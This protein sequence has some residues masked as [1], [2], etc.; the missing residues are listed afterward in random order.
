MHGK[1]FL[2]LSS[3]FLLSGNILA[4]DF[5]TER[6]DKARTAYTIEKGRLAIEPELVNYATQDEDNAYVL[7]AGEIF[8]RA[9]ITKNS[10]LQINTDSYIDQSVKGKKSTTTG[11]TEFGWKYNFHGNDEGNI[12]FAIQPYVYIPTAGNNKKRTWEGGLAFNMEWEFKEKNYLGITIEPN[13]V[14]KDAEELDWQS[15]LVTA[16][17][18]ATPVFNEKLLLFLEF[19]NEYGKNEEQPQI[20]TINVAL[21]YKLS[22]RFFLDIGTFV[23]VSPDADDLESFL[24]GGYLF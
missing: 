7:T 23:G 3:L 1:S 17:S 13:N 24:G 10:E 14:R 15:S 20:T 12:A 16:V 5:V 22:D 6:P 19:F 18:F 11:N 8:I 21:Q 9:G 4:R 2:L